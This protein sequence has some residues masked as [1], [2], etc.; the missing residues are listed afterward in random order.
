MRTDMGLGPIVEYECARFR[1]DIVVSKWKQL[2]KLR[3]SW[4]ILKNTFNPT[5][6]IRLEMMYQLLSTRE[7]F[8]LLFLTRSSRER[9]RGR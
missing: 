2:N 1:V 5:S 8:S 9:V 7:T 4:N 6:P 3:Y